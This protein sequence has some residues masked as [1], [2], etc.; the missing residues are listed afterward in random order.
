MHSFAVGAIALILP[1]P[2]IFTAPVSITTQTSFNSPFSLLTQK[3]R[4]FHILAELELHHL[5]DIFYGTLP[6][7]VSWHLSSTNCEKFN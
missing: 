7:T 1:E 5:T 6:A 3:K 4:N 2:S